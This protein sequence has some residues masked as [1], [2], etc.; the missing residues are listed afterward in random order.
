M[1][2]LKLAV[3]GSDVEFDRGYF[4]SAVTASIFSGSHQ[5]N[6]SGLTNIQ[7]ASYAISASYAPGGS[8][9]SLGIGFT[10]G[11]GSGSFPSNTFVQTNQFTIRANVDSGSSPYHGIETF[12]NKEYVNS[13]IHPSS[14]YYSGSYGI[15]SLNEYGFTQQLSTPYG[16]SILHRYDGSGKSGSLLSSIQNG[17]NTIN[18]SNPTDS[19]RV[20]NIFNI[21]DNLP[22]WL[23][24]ATNDD[25]ANTLNLLI[26]ATPDG[27]FSCSFND[28]RS[29]P[30]GIEY[31]GDYGSA[32]KTNIRSI[33]DV[34]T[35][36]SHLTASYAISASYSLG[37]GGIFSG[38]FIGNGSGLTGITASAG[39]AGLNNSLQFNDGGTASGSSN[40]IFVKSNNTLQLT[41]SLIATSI[42]ASLHGSASYATTSSYFRENKTFGITIDGGGT[43][44]TTGI[45]GDVVIPFDCYIDSWYLTAD[46]VGS[47]VIDVWKD[48][49]ANYPPA[50]AD[51]I[52]GTEKPTLSSQQSNSDTNLTTWS[53]QVISG[54]VIR[55][56][57]DSVS[58]VT[59]VNLTIAA[60]I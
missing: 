50:V 44:I 39:P 9:N 35:I 34:G 49:F 56:N 28:N 20:S 36:R 30:V 59:R 7:S 47:I 27:N 42:T 58:T 3:S 40:L 57:V 37:G 17:Y 12:Y 41:G 32:I 52:A 46:Q 53:K 21:N 14:S 2:W 16:I 33:P 10:S 4:S 11:G 31:G 5:G 22:K 54:D 45:K 48:V 26:T 13:Y 43:V 51:A 24:D 60:K 55:F 18:V 15:L 8:S 29:T 23:I 19:V 1:Q 38:S 6:G 25:T